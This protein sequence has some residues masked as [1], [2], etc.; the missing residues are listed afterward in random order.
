M[1]RRHVVRK[2]LAAAALSAA[3]VLGAA[4]CSGS[5]GSAGSGST[6]GAPAPTVS[7]TPNA[8]TTQSLRQEKAKVDAAQSAVDAADSDAANDPTRQ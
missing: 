1:R 7:S 2:T 3:V 4:A 5:G 8:S 6:G